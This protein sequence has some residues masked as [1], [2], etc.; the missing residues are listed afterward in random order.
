MAMAYVIFK[1]G[2][3]LSS[4][5]GNNMLTQQNSQKNTGDRKE[6]PTNAS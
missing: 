1:V 5:T 3:A 2:K 6:N 4:I